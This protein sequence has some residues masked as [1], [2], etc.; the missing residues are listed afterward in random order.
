MDRAN[1]LDLSRRSRGVTVRELVEGGMH[2]QFL[3]DGV[4]GCIWNE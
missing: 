3:H 4:A 1:A 2:R